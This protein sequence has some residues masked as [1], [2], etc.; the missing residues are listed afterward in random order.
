[1]RPELKLRASRYQPTSG[2]RPAPIHRI[3]VAGA[4]HAVA[5]VHTGVLRCMTKVA[6]TARVTAHTGA[7]RARPAIAVAQRCVRA[8]TRA[9]EL[10]RRAIAVLAAVRIDA[11][12]AGGHA[13]V[14]RCFRSTGSAF[15]W[16][17]ARAIP[18][19]LTG[20]VGA[21]QL[22]RAKVAAPATTI[23]AL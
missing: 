16:G 10:T 20:V 4:A 18:V 3:V 17:V 13:L 11:T 15:A 2:A 21:E 1:M 7:W 14:G 8:K 23:D 5:V 9:V 19:T 6:V 22:T 12:I